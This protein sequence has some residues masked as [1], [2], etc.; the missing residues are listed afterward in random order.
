MGQTPP[1]R[2]TPAPQCRPPPRAPHPHCSAAP[3]RRQGWPPRRPP[4]GQPRVVPASPRQPGAARKQILT[5]LEHG[6][7][8]RGAAGTGLEAPGRGGAGRGEDAGARGDLPAAAER[9]PLRCPASPAAPLQGAAEPGGGAAPAEG[10]RRAGIR[11]PGCGRA[12]G[13]RGGGVEDV[14]LHPRR[15]GW[16][17][18]ARRGVCAERVRGAGKPHRG[19]CE[20][21]GGGG[22]RM[23]S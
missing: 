12:A 16:A 23:G 4:G 22:S 17:A 21:G 19:G 20:G 6:A 3:G 10:G 7:Q 8:A 15:R 1:V 13:E 11:A 5:E 9:S 18:G 2:L 14:C